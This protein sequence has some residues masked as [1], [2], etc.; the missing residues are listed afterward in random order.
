M[1]VRPEK[2]RVLARS[3][4]PLSAIAIIRGSRVP[5]SPRDPE[6][7]TSGEDLRVRTLWAVIERRCSRRDIF[8]GQPIVQV[9]RDD[10]GF[11]DEVFEDKSVRNAVIGQEEDKK[12]CNEEL[13]RCED[14]IS[15]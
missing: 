15:R 2:T 12:I 11:D 6:S 7:S 5:R 1:F 8:Q 13:E 4:E 10:L 3:I 9:V 14:D